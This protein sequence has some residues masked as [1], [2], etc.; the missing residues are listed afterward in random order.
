MDNLIISSFLRKRLIPKNGHHFPPTPFH[1]L[2]YPVRD[3]CL[4]DWIKA[5]A[6]GKPAGTRLIIAIT[7][8]ST[9]RGISSPPPKLLIHYKVTVFSFNMY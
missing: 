3:Q 1:R 8:V 9:A 5:L 2:K 7:Q 4:F 6:E